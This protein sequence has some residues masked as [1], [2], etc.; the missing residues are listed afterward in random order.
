MVD[1][2]KA[3]LTNLKGL[4]ISHITLEHQKKKEGIPL[5][6]LQ[7]RGNP[8]FPHSILWLFITPD[9]AAPAHRK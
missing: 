9:G 6:G 8:A 4:I 7:G 5:L 3:E 1:K 2:T